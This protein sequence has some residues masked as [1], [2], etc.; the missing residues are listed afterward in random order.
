MTCTISFA[1]NLCG[2]TVTNKNG[3]AAK[4]EYTREL[5]RDTLVVSDDWI[6]CPI[7]ICYG[8]IN[9]VSTLPRETQP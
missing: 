2:S 7:H 1:C 9:Q 4:W 8:C 6:N 5:S 3:L